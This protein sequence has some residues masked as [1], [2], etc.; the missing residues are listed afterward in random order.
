VQYLAQTHLAHTNDLH[1]HGANASERCPTDTPASHPWRD[2]H[3]PSAQPQHPVAGSLTNHT[4]RQFPLAARFTFAVRAQ[5]GS[6]RSVSP[7]SY[8]FETN[9]RMSMPSV[10]G[11]LKTT[12]RK[13][14]RTN[15]SISSIGSRSTSVSMIGCLAR[16]SCSRATFSG[17]GPSL[18]QERRRPVWRRKL[19]ERYLA[20]NRC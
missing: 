9:L 14:P 1:L 3:H 20:P 4:T 11:A 12:T 8:P 18:H 10:S 13:R 6:Q 15:G 16:G 2:L 5:T 7:R 19:R 17:P